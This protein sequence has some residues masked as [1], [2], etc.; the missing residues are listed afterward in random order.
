MS[1]ADYLKGKNKVKKEVDLLIIFATVISL[2]PALILIIVLPY[3]KIQF[4][5]IYCHFAIIFAICA[6][7]GVHLQNKD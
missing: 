1:F 4:P 7:I 3:L 6:L 5:S 2:V